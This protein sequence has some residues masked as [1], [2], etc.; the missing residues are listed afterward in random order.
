MPLDGITLY[1]LHQELREVLVGCRVDKIHQPARD[2]LLFTLR[3][4]GGSFR[5]LL[6]ANA[7][8]TRLHLTASAPENPAAPPMLCMLLRKHLTGSAVTAITQNGLDRIVT[9]S[10]AGTNE[11]GDKTTWQL[12]VECMAKHS[13]IILCDAD[14]LIIDAVKRIGAAQSSVRQ[15]Q[16]GLSYVLPPSQNKLSLLEQTPRQ[17]TD[18]VFLQQEKS[19]ANALLQQ[20]EGLSPLLC[21]EIASL[22][23]G[24]TELGVKLLPDTTKDRLTA[25]FENLQKE[26][27]NGTGTPTMLKDAQGKP[28]EFSFCDITQ[29]GFSLQ[30]QQYDSYSELLDAFYAERDSILRSRQRAADLH[31]LLHNA[32]A[33]VAK[34]LHTQRLEL[35]E[36][37]DREHLRIKAEL[38]QANMHTLQKG[39]LY[40][41]L[42][43]YYTNE[44]MRIPADPARTPNENAQKY[45]KDYRKAK[46]AQE[47]LTQLIEAG[48]AD[49]QY[50]ETVTD[51]LERA[52]S[53]EEIQAIRDELTQTGYCKNRQGKKGKKE[54]PLPPFAYTSSDGFT[55]LVGR[56]NLQNDQ[57]SFKQ[58]AKQDLWLHTQT[59]PGSHVIVLT[60]GKE[61]PDNTILEAAQIAA[62]HSKARQST[63]VAVDY[64]PV[65]QLKKPAGAKP[66]K[67]IYHTHYTVTVDPKLPDR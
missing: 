46:T 65:K 66:G 44:T 10:F 55:I 40:Y 4:R 38:I 45:Y 31:K 17:I 14:G 53:Y 59:I 33:R 27:Q 50:L 22:V 60:E 7:N 49:L 5:L 63:Q 6:S 32:T 9:I 1:F 61:L 37:E 23:S 20:V 3:T 15:I 62:Y 2:E 35:A 8:N 43:N 30:A 52:V 58:A 19:L 16:P 26:L 47:K 56:N 21:R 67:V 42:E 29:Y 18:T 36:S 51:A 11:L 57:L 48:E 54:K 41:D 13:N 24:N 25:Y 12:H 39:A 64:T 28:S 34:K